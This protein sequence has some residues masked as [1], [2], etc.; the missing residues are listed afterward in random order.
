MGSCTPEPCEAG[1]RASMSNTS[2]PDMT[3]LIHKGARLSKLC[4]VWSRSR[5]SVVCIQE[6][7]DAGGRLK[8]GAPRNADPCDVGTRTPE[9][10]EGGSIRGNRCD[11][12]GVECRGSGLSI[13]ELPSD[14]LQLCLAR[15]PRKFQP[16]LKVVCRQWQQ[17]ADSRQLLQVGRGWGWDGVIVRVGYCRQVVAPGIHM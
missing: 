10:F 8:V 1:F 9:R 16:R 15:V 6:P 2:T 13:S 5:D 12:E 3:D 7:C 14:L 11:S 17:L 4:D